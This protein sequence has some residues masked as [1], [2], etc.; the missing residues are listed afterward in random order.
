MI[1]LAHASG[2][3]PHFSQDGKEVEKTVFIGPIRIFVE[4]K[5]GGLTTHDLVIGCNWYRGCETKGCGYSW[6][7]RQE[8]KKMQARVPA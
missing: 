4:A 2:V 7:S 5:E 3:C 6:V 8:R 1:E